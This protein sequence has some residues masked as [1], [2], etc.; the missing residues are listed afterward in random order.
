M[1]NLDTYAQLEESK[2]FYAYPLK[3]DTQH[4]NSADLMAVKN[5]LATNT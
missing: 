5:I 1:A 2:N 3:H 4:N